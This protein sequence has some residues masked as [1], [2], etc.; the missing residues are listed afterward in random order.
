MKKTQIKLANPKCMPHIGSVDAA[1]MDLRLYLGDNPRVDCSV[2]EPGEC[3][4]YNTGVS[5]AIPPGWVGLVVPRSSVGSK[6]KIRVSNTVGVID[7]DYRGEIKLSLHNF[8]TEAQL[9]Y[10]FDRLCQ[11][12]IVPYLPPDFHEIVDELGSTERGEGGFGSTGTN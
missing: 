3:R 9:L 6:M 10:N 7:S 8:G 1:G 11:M 2:L 5:V 4:V 12:V